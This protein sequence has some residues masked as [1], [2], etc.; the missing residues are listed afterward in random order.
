MEAPSD[1]LA[2]PRFVR[3]S[4]CDI[5]IFINAILLHV[6][7]NLALLNTKADKR[8]KGPREK[9][10]Y[11]TWFFLW[12]GAPGEIVLPSHHAMLSNSLTSFFLLPQ[13]FR[14]LL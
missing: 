9:S 6:H 7:L 2:R 12:K 8:V 4:A 13:G 11:P 1:R 3:F 14:I 10:S 5:S